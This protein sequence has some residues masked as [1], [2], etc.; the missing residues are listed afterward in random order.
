M[1]KS[2]D[3]ID[4]SKMCNV[5]S[6]QVEEVVRARFA[7]PAVHPNMQALILAGIT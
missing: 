1:Q 3:C 6:V 4:A 7:C 2:C 5:F